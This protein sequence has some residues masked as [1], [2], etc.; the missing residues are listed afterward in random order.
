M[1][2]RRRI[3]ECHSEGFAMKPMHTDLDFDQTPLLVIWE[4]TRACALACQHCRAA[5]IDQRDPLELT[6][7]E[8]KALI[9]DVVKMGTPLIVFTGG[10]PLQRVDL[11][12]LIRHA[13]SRDLRVGAIPAATPRMTRERL[14]SLRDAGVHQL[15]MSLDGSTKQRHDDFRQVEGSFDLTMQ[16]AAWAR[17][18]EI[19]LQ[20]NTVLGQYNY[21]DFDAL[22]DW[23]VRLGVVF[24]EVFFLVEV[25]RGTELKGCTPEQC[26]DLFARLYKMAQTCGFKIKVTEAPHYRRHVMQNSNGAAPKPADG[27]VFHRADV[28]HPLRPYVGMGVNDG[29]G[30]VF[31]DHQ[32][33]VC[34]SGFLP[35]ECGN[36]RQ[37]SIIDI[38]RDSPTFKALRNIDL[39]EGRCGAC[40]YRD[41]C[42]GSR[43]RAFAADGNMQS[44]DKSCIY[45]PAAG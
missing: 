11:E 31:V 30:F 39:L 10:D 33:N 6:T 38:Y 23:A 42:G 43:A 21:D 44:E 9:D 18:L 36:I 26:E 13:R 1:T 15:A 16:G 35:I 45:D 4:V 17:E 34:P 29:K 5:A 3:V 28:P 7:D 2:I 37:T 41:M 32:G 40:E 19:P 24:W 25:G 12:E 27:K 14:Q 20:I 8:G 22:A